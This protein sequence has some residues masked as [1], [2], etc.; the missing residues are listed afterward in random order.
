MTY[1]SNLCGKEIARLRP[2]YGSLIQT[3]A[4]LDYTFFELEH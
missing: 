2:N 4:M 3:H 1:D